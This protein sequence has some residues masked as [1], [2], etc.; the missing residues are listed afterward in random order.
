MPVRGFPVSSL[1]V[2]SEEGGGCY[3]HLGE[4]VDR[5]GGRHIFVHGLALDARLPE[6][7]ALIDG[8]VARAREPVSAKERENATDLES[9]KSADGEGAVIK[10]VSG[11]GG[12]GRL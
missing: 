5:S 1:S 2:I 6:S 11:T 8:L 4:R 9:P 3:A 10:D 12:D 7:L